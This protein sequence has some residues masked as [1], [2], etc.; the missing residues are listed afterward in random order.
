M[1]RVKVF[2]AE[3]PNVLEDLI[4]AWLDTM[5]RGGA[6]TSP[7]REIELHCSEIRDS[8]GN[9]SHMHYVSLIRY[10]T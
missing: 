9:F 6:G 1:Q 3:Y 10:E 5:A 8:D 4:N 2:T 7:I